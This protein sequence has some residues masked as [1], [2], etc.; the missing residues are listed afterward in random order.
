[1]NKIY[2]LKAFQQI[3]NSYVFPKVEKGREI[4]TNTVFV[5]F[6]E[7]A[8]QKTWDFKENEEAE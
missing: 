6:L 5:H 4:R 1:M 8:R 2:M 7:I 3:E